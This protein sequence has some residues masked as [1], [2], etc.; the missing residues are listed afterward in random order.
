[1]SLETGFCQ[2]L[3]IDLIQ[4]AKNELEFLEEVS[5][6]PNLSSGPLVRNAITRYELFWLP[7]ASQ[8]LSDAQLAA[9]PLDVAWV[10]HAHMLAPHYYQQD[11]Q[12]ILSKVLDHS[13]LDRTQ[14]DRVQNDVEGLWRQ[15]YPDEPF[16]VD[17]TKP[18]AMATSYPSNI[19]YN[20][21]EAC[22]RQFKFIYQVSLPHYKDEL[23]LKMAV[24]RYVHHLGLMR[25]HRDEFM[26]PCYDLDLIWHTHRLYP[27]S[28]N[29]SV[30]ELLGTPLYHDDT[31]N[32]GSK[33]YD[34][35]LKTTAVWEAVGLQYAKPGAM[36][37]GEPPDPV[38]VKPKWLY[39]P[40]ASVKY[41]IS[42][43][44]I[45]PLG[46]KKDNTFIIRLQSKTRGII[47]SQSFR[48]SSKDYLFFHCTFDDWEEFPIEFF[49]YK[50][51]LFGEKMITKEEID[52]LPLYE[53]E[54]KPVFD[55]L[56]R[57]SQRITV[58]VPIDKEK[59]TAKVTITFQVVAQIAEYNFQVQPKRVFTE[60]DHPSLILGCSG[61]MLSPSD[62]AK[63]SVPCDS[64]TH[65]VFDSRGN[66]VFSCR[67]VHSSDALLSAAELI[68]V[69]GQVVTTTHTIS[70]GTLPEKDDVQDH[71]NSIFFNQAEGERAMLIRGDTDW[72]VCIGK[73]Q[74][75]SERRSFARSYVGVKV[76]KLS[77]KHGWCLV[78]KS[79]HGCFNIKTDSDTEVKIN[80]KE[81][82]IVIS[83]RA[84][85]IP[86][87]LALAFSV[88][89]LYLLCL[90]HDPEPSQESTQKASKFHPDTISS[91]FYSAGYL[92]TKVPTNVYL[93]AVGKAC[94]ASEALGK[95]GSYDFAGDFSKDW[96]RGLEN[97]GTKRPQGGVQS[98]SKS[99][100]RKARSNGA[101][102]ARFTDTNQGGYIG[103][104]Y[105]NSYDDLYLFDEDDYFGRDGCGYNSFSG[106]GAWEGGGGS[107]VGGGWKG[108]GGG[109]GGGGWEGGGGCG[110]GGC[111][112]DD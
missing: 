67:V 34:S 3:G 60:C 43:Y 42:T 44:N 112:G 15:T 103:K 105:G 110:G 78:T 55:G 68:D 9:P 69:H 45:K 6:Y 62:L 2:G 16:H 7:L 10:W 101:R 37:R 54:P 65:P 19:Q 74:K 4:A 104:D 1:M 73:W 92:S 97:A 83:P 86:E 59:S 70:P 58:D 79:P 27:V 111:D 36:Y 108:G 40:L 80:L 33:L 93:A 21:E 106:G 63:P 82:T 17:L 22:S 85:D 24:E 72:A 57:Q 53:A 94:I 96:N 47:I 77:G 81:N 84:Q 90:P 61:L 41:K 75:E 91:S 5:T 32:L 30:K 71:K 107:G 11:C 100:Q 50:K 99:G 98:I 35:K 95:T 20:L 28:Y 46:M 18:P 52:L 89:I 49:L 109:G 64:S 26:V 76:Y 31:M 39:A 51:K 87:L 14:R 66:Q 29:Q 88:S 8:Y 25:L 12:N 48:G 13:P 56:G 38:P 23:F 102:G